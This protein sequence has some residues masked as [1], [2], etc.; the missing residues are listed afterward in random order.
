MVRWLRGG[1]P[2]GSPLLYLVHAPKTS[3]TSVNAL[4]RNQYLT[5]YDHTE[6]FLD[7]EVFAERANTADWMSGHAS[8]AGVQRRLNGILWRPVRYFTVL[9]EPRRQLISHYNWLLEIRHRG[10][11]FF[12]SHPDSAKRI[13]ERL[14]QT[15]NRDPLAVIEN[16]RDFRSL[17]ENSQA[18]VVVDDNLHWQA[19]YLSSVLSTYTFIARS[20]QIGLLLERMTG[21]RPVEVPRANRSTYRFDTGVFATPELDRFLRTYNVKDQE[22]WRAA[23]GGHLPNTQP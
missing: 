16:L 9:R 15:D 3:G 5:G 12:E 2:V 6:A 23:T 19:G 20:D 13:S 8:S 10:R 1:D 4:L 18:R 17:F 22:L 14:A 11:R 7:D 21:R